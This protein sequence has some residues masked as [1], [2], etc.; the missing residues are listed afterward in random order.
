[1]KAIDTVQ[2]LAQTIL[3]MFDEHEEEDAALRLQYALFECRY[4]YLLKCTVT[5]MQF[6][7]HLERSAREKDLVDLHIAIR[8]LDRENSGAIDA[9]AYELS[10]GE[11]FISRVLAHST[12]EDTPTPTFL[13]DFFSQL[14]REFTEA[15]EALALIAQQT[16]E[17]QFHSYADYFA[18]H[19]TDKIKTHIESGVDILTR[20]EIVDFLCS[21]CLSV[22]SSSEISTLQRELMRSP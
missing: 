21:D 5:Q 4:R 22:L 1:M 10:H 16:P 8:D 18:I 3:I 17:A 12:H 19:L 15:Y 7:I 2:S 13:K 20:Q 6:L 9:A 14:L 11:S